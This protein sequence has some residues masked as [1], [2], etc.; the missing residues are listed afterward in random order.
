[1][2]RRDLFGAMVG[3]VAA[4]MG[5]KLVE[6]RHPR[7]WKLVYDVDTQPFPVATYRG[8]PFPVGAQDNRWQALVGRTRAGDVCVYSTVP[9]V[10]VVPFRR[11]T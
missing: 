2:K 10:K 9:T 7:K 8:V 6:P 11:G 3:A 5:V 4:M 1:M